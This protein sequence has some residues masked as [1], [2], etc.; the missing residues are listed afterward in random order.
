M[1]VETLGEALRA[2]WRL[3]VRCAL[4]KRDGLKSIR[5][6]Q[7]EAELD[8]AS[9]VWTRGPNFP[10]ARMSER[11]M[12]PACGSRRVA[13]VFVPPAPGGETAVSSGAA[14]RRSQ[15]AAMQ[16]TVEHWSKGALH[17]LLAASPN[18][19]IAR[20]AFACAKSEVRLE[21]G[22]TI[23]LKQVMRVLDQH[24]PREPYARDIPIE[25]AKAQWDR[26]RAGL[27]KGRKRVWK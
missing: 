26:T 27:P 6:C 23:E 12:C 25:E 10:I 19:E 15:L 2:G 18:P 5:E 8:L 20:A 11:L 16:Y 21:E 3:Q 24:P 14:D 9:V 7:R 17:R 22:D 13:V 4:G 1:S